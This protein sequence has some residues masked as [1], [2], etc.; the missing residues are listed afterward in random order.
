MAEV[1]QKALADR[2]QALRLHIYRF[3][4]EQGRPPSV[5]ENASACGLRDSAALAAWRRLHDAHLILL[6]ADGAGIR[7]ANPL[8][9]LPTRFRVQVGQHWLFA[10]CAWDAPGI[11]AMLGQDVVI[12]ARC[13]PRGERLRFSV[14]DGEL[15][16]E[17]A[18]VHFALPFRHWYDDLV[19]T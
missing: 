1:S 13:S 9:A 16:A 17:E 11:S 10:N 2:D 3:W 7:M 8:S 5:A 15:L 6:E 12:E 19:E 14:R 18:L 4:C